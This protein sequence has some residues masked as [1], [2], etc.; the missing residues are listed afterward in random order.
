MTTDVQ[1]TFDRT[2]VEGKQR[3]DRTWAGLAATGAVGGAD[4]GLGLLAMLVVRADTG[5]PVLGALAFGVGFLALTLAGSEL[6]TENFLVPFGPLITRRSRWR[7]LVRLWVIT[8]VT[9]LLA[10]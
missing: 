9:N 7:Q 6:F 4:V 5:S 3:L 10:G 8:L 2:V 1:T